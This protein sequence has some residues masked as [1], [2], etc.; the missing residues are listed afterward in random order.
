MKLRQD[1]AIAAGVTAALMAAFFALPVFV[2]FPICIAV[3]L[4]IAFKTGLR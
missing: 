3:V 2:W 4:G 1:D